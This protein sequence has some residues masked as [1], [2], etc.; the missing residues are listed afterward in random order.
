MNLTPELAQKITKLI[1]IACGTSYYSGLAG[2]HMIESIARLPTEV[3]YASEFRYYDPIVDAGTAV[4]AITQSGETADTL[5]ACELA[6]SKGA[7]LWSIVNAVGSQSTRISD[8]YIP[9]HAGPE[10]GV[11]STKA[12][13]TSLTD[14]YLLALALGQLRCTLTP[15]RRAS[16]STI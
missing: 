13:T 4:L 6:K 1:I 14:Q 3:A 5:A 12:F 8:G 10:I 9:M 7:T 2:K 15:Q 16:L 11:A